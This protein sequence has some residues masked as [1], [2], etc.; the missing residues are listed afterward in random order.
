MSKA[1]EFIN[2]KLGDKNYTKDKYPMYRKE[3]AEWLNEF[4]EVVKESDS[5]RHVSVLL[6]ELEKQVC[7]LSTEYAKCYLGRLNEQQMNVREDLIMLSEILR[8]LK[9]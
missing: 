6:P 4:T 8:V 5:L 9:Q 3:I 1:E 2:N 7:H